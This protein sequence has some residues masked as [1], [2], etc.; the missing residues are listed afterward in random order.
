MALA[1][2]EASGQGKLV[3]A[4]RT[5]RV[6]SE[7][8]EPGLAFIAYPIITRQG[9]GATGGARGVVVLG[10]LEDLGH[11]PRL[12]KAR[13]RTHGRESGQDDKPHVP[14]RYRPDQRRGSRSH[15]D[16][17]HHQEAL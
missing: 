8:I 9:G 5:G 14:G 2:K 7:R 16:D 6:V 4:T 13:P 11:E 1:A 15:T 10:E 12:L 17:A 3:A